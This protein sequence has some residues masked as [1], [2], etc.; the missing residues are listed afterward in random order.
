MCWNENFSRDFDRN[1]AFYQAVFGYEYGDMTGEFRYA[2]LK[3][4]G[5]EV[6]GIGELGSGMPAGAR[7]LVHLFRG[8]RHRRR[9]QSRTAAGGA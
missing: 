8:R 2:T 5:N 7:A 1:Q 9:R 4:D 6:G 3:L